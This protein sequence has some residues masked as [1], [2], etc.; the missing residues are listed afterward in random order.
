MTYPT[1]TSIAAR[2]SPLEQNLLVSQTF[3]AS[4]GSLFPQRLRRSTWKSC[5]VNGKKK[6]RV[7]TTEEHLTEA[8]EER[9]RKKDNSKLNTLSVSLRSTPSSHC[10]SC[11]VLPYV[12]HVCMWLVL[13]FLSGL[14]KAKNNFR[15]GFLPFLLVTLFEPPIFL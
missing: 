9:R 12:S 15:N 14:L 4:L 10:R 3:L 8:K 1:F 13:L 11:L 6:A 7:S 2:K 5:Y